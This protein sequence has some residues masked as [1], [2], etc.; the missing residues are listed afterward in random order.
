MQTTQHL[1]TNILH[2]VTH[3]TV[4]AQLCTGDFHTTVKNS[5]KTVH[6]RT[7]DNKQGT[8]NS[9]GRECRVRQCAGGFRRH[10][11]DTAR[12]I[13][14]AHPAAGTHARLLVYAVAQHVRRA[15]GTNPLSTFNS[16]EGNSPLNAPRFG[17]P[18]A[19]A[20]DSPSDVVLKVCAANRVF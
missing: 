11:P 13:L 15:V 10:S 2:T 8:H 17:Q 3:T 20:T 1:N 6:S 16:S 4:S 18:A 12:H 7:A 19:M 9:G 5:A 14:A